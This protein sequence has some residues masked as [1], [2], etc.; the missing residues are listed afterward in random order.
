MADEIMS[1]LFLKK[2]KAIVGDRLLTAKT[3]AI[4]L[5]KAKEYIKTLR[6]NKVWVQTESK[7]KYIRKFRLTQIINDCFKRELER[8]F[9]K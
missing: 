9:P 4:E 2:N 3:D 8:E 6:F 1:S 5:N 7:P